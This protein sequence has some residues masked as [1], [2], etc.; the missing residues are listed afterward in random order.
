MPEESTTPDAVELTRKQ[1][2]AVNSRDFD[3]MMSYWGPESVWDMPEAGLGEYK[4]PAAIRR[5]AE[6]W[7]GAY[8]EYEIK[9]EQILDLGNG[10][11]LAEVT[12]KGR[13]AGSTGRVQLRYVAVN[14]WEEGVIVRVT[15][16]G[17]SDEARAAAERL[18]EERG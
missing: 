5:F 7:I 12:Q 10:V 16:Y 2:E 1:L 8:D 13:L 6:D 11:S 4:G 17:D 3:A 18:S 14:A 15:V 9:P